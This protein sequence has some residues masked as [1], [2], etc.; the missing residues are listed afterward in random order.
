MS[1]FFDRVS[2]VTLFSINILCN[3]GNV[4]YHVDVYVVG[5]FMGS[6]T[7]SFVVDF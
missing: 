2:T 1:V 4:L 7:S 5:L 6:E 3:H